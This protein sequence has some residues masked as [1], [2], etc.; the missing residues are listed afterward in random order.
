M[1]RKKK[2]ANAATTDRDMNECQADI[3]AALAT[4]RARTEAA[5]TRLDDQGNQLKRMDESM[6]R[7][8]DALVHDREQIER[9]KDRSIQNEVDIVYLSSGLD[10][11]TVNSAEAQELI[12]TTS[13]TT[14]LLVRNLEGF[15]RQLESDKEELMEMIESRCREGTTNG[16]LHNKLEIPTFENAAYEVFKRPTAILQCWEHNAANV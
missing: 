13:Q 1:G 6:Q 12:K 7:A 11:L 5:H 2:T 3:N 9:I 8:R 15:N 16:P 14:S 4:L 10:K